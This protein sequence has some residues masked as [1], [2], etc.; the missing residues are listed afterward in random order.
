M[1]STLPLPREDVATRF[2]YHLLRSSKTVSRVKNMV[3]SS[4]NHGREKLNSMVDLLADGDEHQKRSF[5]MNALQQRSKKVIGLASGGVV[6]SVIPGVGSL[7]GAIIG[8]S[9]ADSKWAEKKVDQWLG[10]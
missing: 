1:K 9:L 2:V 10:K 3:E 4:G 8:Y 6:G 5:E 7:L